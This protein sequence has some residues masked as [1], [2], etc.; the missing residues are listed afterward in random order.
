MCL[1]RSSAIKGDVFMAIFKPFKALR[2]VPEYADKVGA[3]PYDVMNSAEAK[4][5]TKDNPLSFLH[6]D[7]AEI[8][9]PE[10]TD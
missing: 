3:L 4:E 7:K 1:S 2:P 10:G 5:M 8:D 9:L 6:V